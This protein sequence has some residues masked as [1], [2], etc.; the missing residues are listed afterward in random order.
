MC[1]YIVPQR[2]AT[3]N[4]SISNKC[5]WGCQTTYTLLHI[6]WDSPNITN[7]WINVYRMIHTLLCI[8]FPKNPKAALLNLN[9]PNCTNDQF[10]LLTFLFTVAKQTLAKCWWSS[11]PTSTIVIVPKSR[12]PT[13]MLPHPSGVTFGSFQ[14]GGGD[15]SPHS[16]NGLWPDLL[17]VQPPSSFP[18]H[19]AN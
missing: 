4:S 8:R 13:Y 2:L 19:W 9:P 7:F 14:E 11:L 12:T 10:R 3:I 18:R 5:F 15:P 1:W 6:C 16:G 17:E